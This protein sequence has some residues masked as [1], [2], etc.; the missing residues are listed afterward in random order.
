MFANVLFP[1]LWETITLTHKHT[2]TGSAHA[3]IKYRERR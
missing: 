2:G 3:F 1:A